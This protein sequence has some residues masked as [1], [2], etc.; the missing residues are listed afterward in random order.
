M[1]A[2]KSREKCDQ[3]C[4]QQYN[5]DVDFTAFFYMFPKEKIDAADDQ[6]DTSGKEEDADRHDV[7]DGTDESLRIA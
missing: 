2:I 4:D 6:I 7:P 5:D 1:P 3:R